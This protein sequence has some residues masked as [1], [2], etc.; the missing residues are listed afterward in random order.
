MNISHIGEPTVP[1]VRIRGGLLNRMWRVETN[2]GVFAV[3]ELTRDRDWVYFHDDIFRLELAA[4]SAGIPMPE[5]LSA[6]DTTL[7]H[8]W[9]EG[10]KVPE[11]PVSESFAFEIGELLARLHSLD[12]E[13]PHPLVEISV[14]NDWADLAEQAVDTGQPWADEFVSAVDSFV[15]ISVFVDACART[16][17]VVLTHRDINPRNLLNAGGHPILLDWEVAGRAYLAA[18]LGATALNVAKGAD[19]DHIEPTVFGAVLDGYVAGGG[20][21]PPRGPDWFVDQL[22]GWAAFVRWN[23][24]RCL[25]S[26]EATTGPE[27]TLSHD[28]VRNGLSGLP[29]MLAW[30][31]SLE[32]LLVT[33]TRA[34]HNT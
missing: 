16:G 8:R 34:H 30:M 21:L 2:Q 23:M 18:E 11:E 10:S 32:D 1:M 4:F 31:P 15:A 9:V 28:T 13:W 24:L 29:D 6:D 19:F 14:T 7:V 12:V 5:P 25:D 17:P 26:I 20:T 27:L 22:G 33:S 3:K